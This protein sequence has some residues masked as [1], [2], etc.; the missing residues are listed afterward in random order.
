MELLLNRRF[1]QK[2]LLLLS[3]IISKKCW[4]Y[5]ASKINENLIFII[6]I[7]NLIN[8]HQR[9]ITNSQNLEELSTIIN[10]WE[11]QKIYASTFVEKLRKI[12]SEKVSS[13]IFLHFKRT[14]KKE[15][16]Q[17]NFFGFTLN[18]KQENSG[19]KNNASGNDSKHNKALIRDYKLIQ[20]NNNHFLCFYRLIGK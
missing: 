5:V 9:T 12:I 4:L 6:N 1:S 18:L 14:F 15:F 3:V 17:A 7:I 20:V 11:K 2:I 13:F 19:P 10:N 16:F 8:F